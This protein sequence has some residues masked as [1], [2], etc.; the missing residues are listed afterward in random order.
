[1]CLGVFFLPGVLT[2]VQKSNNT[3]EAR[4][5]APF[6][7]FSIRT[8]LGSGYFTEMD[9]YLSDHFG[10]R[11]YFVT[12]YGR[13][14][15][16]L[17]VS[18]HD[19]VLVGKNNWLFIRE[20][21]IEQVTGQNMYSNDE[22]V[23]LA[24]NIEEYK[25]I[26]EENDAVFYFFIAPNK[27]SIYPEQLPAYISVADY[28]STDQ[29]IEYLRDN[30]DIAVI[31]VRAE[32]RAE[33]ETYTLYY[34]TDTHWNDYAGYIA[35]KKLYSYI[36]GVDVVPLEDFDI[37]TPETTTGGGDLARL[38]GTKGYMYENHVGLNRKEAVDEKI[39]ASGPR[40][41]LFA[42]SFSEAMMQFVHPHF[43]YVGYERRKLFIPGR[44]TDETPDIVVLEVVERNLWRLLE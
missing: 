15:Y 43:S 32:L 18:A 23:T 30:T 16:S 7:S 14:L 13:A 3:D 36:D 1:M 21:A 40:I 31:D 19:N 29:L 4:A 9:N 6:P 34:H 22:L 24:N 37:L 27:H 11:Q 35:T 10:L 17:G 26:V 20:H 2:V 25:K 28:T 12:T 42:D 38:M 44:I 39:T 33:K 41:L 5:L 8:V